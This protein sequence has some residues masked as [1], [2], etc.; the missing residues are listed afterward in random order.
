MIMKTVPYFRGKIRGKGEYPLYMRDSGLKVRGNVKVLKGTFILAYFTCYA[1]CIA[2][3]EGLTLT[4]L[5]IEEVIRKQGFLLTEYSQKKSQGA[6]RIAKYLKKSKK[7]GKV[8]IS[9]SDKGLITG[10]TPE[11]MNAVLTA[12]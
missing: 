5:F 11:I 6:S 4:T 7:Q 10:I 2:S 1:A 9:V 8:N 3:E 12:F